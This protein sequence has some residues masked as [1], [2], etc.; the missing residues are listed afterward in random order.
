MTTT[1]HGY[2]VHEVGGELKPYE[3]ELGELGPNEVDINVKSCGICYSDVSMID[4]DWGFS[5]YPMVPGHEIIGEV[6]AIGEQVTHLSV[7]D[8]VGVGWHSGYCMVCSEC[9]SGNHHMCANAV[10]TFIGRPG[11]YADIVRAQASAIFKIPRGVELRTAGPLMCGGITVFTPFSQFNISPAASVGVVGI[12]GLGHLALKF[13]RAWGCH[14][15]AFTST[16]E[17]QQEALE[18]GAHD[19][20]NSRDSDAIA[21]ASNRFDL[22]L[23]TVNVPLDWNTYLGTLKKRGRMHILGA[24][25]EPL[26]IV[27]PQMMMAHRSVS[28]SAAGSPSDIE[29]MLSFVE[30]HGISP[31]TEHFPFDQIND[32]VDHVRSG[33]ARYRVV[34][35]Y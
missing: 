14:V 10:V 24:V 33:K 21:R 34:L 27:V 3:Y 31:T 20:L 23:S 6:R 17:K 13:A 30:R 25:Q 9:M 29:K 7:G 4:N 16:E 32:A 12:G 2:A 5:T 35:E 26:G 22:L 19:V 15:T 8:N 1:V 28:S 11:G 18:M